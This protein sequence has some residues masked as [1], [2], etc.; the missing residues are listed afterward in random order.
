[1]PRTNS[2]PTPTPEL[3]RS[4]ST[5][6]L[7][8]QSMPTVPQLPGSPAAPSRSPHA[9]S[10]IPS[11]AAR[12]AVPNISPRTA[13]GRG[14]AALQSTSVPG[15]PVTAKMVRSESAGRRSDTVPEGFAVPLPNSMLPSNDSGG[16]RLPQPRAEK[17]PP[18]GKLFFFEAVFLT[19]FQKLLR[20]RLRR[21]RRLQLLGDGRR[22]I[23]VPTL[24]LRR[25]GRWALRVRP[26]LL[27]PLPPL[28][29]GRVCPS[30]A[31]RS[32]LRGR[33]RVW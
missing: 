5:Q 21:G 28:R 26:F 14:S 17:P 19:L 4:N 6:G 2:G 13:A 27:L 10:A 29:L 30:S 1:M 20:L 3:S 9:A 18:W 11:A 32:L 8:S 25:V 15:S 31:W 23:Q 16:P 12:P 7:M 24:L 22:L 33:R